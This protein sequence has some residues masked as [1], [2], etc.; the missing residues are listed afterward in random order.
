MFSKPAPRIYNCQ[1]C[2]KGFAR[3][4]NLNRH[5]LKHVDLNFYHCDQCGVSF[6]RQEGLS[7]HQFNKHQV[8]GKRKMETGNQ[9]P[10]KKIKKDPR[11]FYSLD[12]VSERK[13][14]KFNTTITTYKVTTND[15]EI[16]DIKEIYTVLRVLFTSVIEDITQFSDQDDLIHL[17]VYSPDLDFPIQLPFMK[18][19]HLT[20]D[21]ILSE[22]ERVLQSFEEFVL[23]GAFE[24][25]IIH[26]KNPSGGVWS[27]HYIDLDAFFK[28]KKCII[29][30]QNKDELCCA[31]AI[32]TAKAK[33][34]NHPLFKE[35]I[36]RGRGIQGKLAKE[37]HVK[38]NVP[39][40]VC[41]IDEIKSFQTVLPDYQIHVVSRDHFNGMI[42]TGPE[43]DKKIYLYLHNNHYDVI[44]SMA[45]FF[46]KAYF[47]TECNTRYDKKK[48]TL[49]I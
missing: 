27:S 11:K 19:S 45:A 3:E 28:N 16:K 24:V 26:V 7:Q 39:F 21:H 2:D 37:L 25:D 8:D 42:Y 47:C 12:K 13:I 46:N 38:A 35:S 31:R 36:K 4:D 48:N 10:L 33:I 17:A 44:T 40:G 23:D 41:G 49:V 5:L 1:V 9:P 15:L 43:A 22:V 14:P 34:D 18:T 32:I 29:R 20:A 6:S 30:I